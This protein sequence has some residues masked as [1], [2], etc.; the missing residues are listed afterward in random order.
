[1]AQP[2]IHTSFAAGELTPALFARVDLDKYHVG[3]ALLKNFFVDYRGGA[4]T[5]MGTEFIAAAGS[6]NQPRLIPFQFSTVATY[7][8]E[9][10]TNLS[11][12]Y[13]NIYSNG[14]PIL[15][16]PTLVS[17]YAEANLPLLKYAQSADTMTLTHPDYPVYLIKRLAANNFTIS[18]MVIGPTTNS[19]GAITLFPATGGVG[20]LSGY[21]VTAV[22]PAGTEESVPSPIKYLLTDH[23]DPAH[24]VGMKWIAPTGTPPSM[25]KIYKWGP[26]SPNGTPTTVMPTAFGYIGSAFTTQFCDNGITPDFTRQPPQFSDPISPGQITGITITNPGGAYPND[27]PP[28]VTISDGSLAHAVIDWNAGVGGVVID[29]YAHG[30]LVNPT[31]SFSGGS[32]GSGAAASV[33][34]LT[35]LIGTYPSCCSFFQQRLCLGSSLN[36]PNQIWMSQTGSVYNFDASTPTQPSDSITISLAS[37]QVNQ[38]KSMVPMPT[39]LI[40]FTSG[41]AWLLSGGGQ[42]LGVTPTNVTAQPQA[43]SGANDMPP[44]VVNNDVLYVQSRGSTV[45][46]LIYNFY[47]NSYFGQDR[48]ALAN[49]LFFGFQLKEWCFAEEP[50]RTIWAIRDDGVALCLTYVPEQEVYA[51]SHH[52]TQGDFISCCSVVEGQ[53]DAVY[54]IVRR[55]INGAVVNQ[56]E[57]LH[58]RNFYGNAEFPFCLDAGLSLPQTYPNAMI[59]FSAATGNVTIT[60]S[61]S[62]FAPGNVGSVLR[63]LRGGKANITGYI[64]GTQITATVVPDGLG[65]NHFPHVPF[66]NGT[67]APIPANYW[68]IGVPTTTIAGLEYLAGEEVYALADGQVVGPLTVPSSSGGF[69]MEALENYSPSVVAQINANFYNTAPTY[70]MA[71]A[72]NQVVGTAFDFISRNLM[73]IALILTPMASPPDSNKYGWTNAT[74]FTLW[75]GTSPYANGSEIDGTTALSPYIGAKNIDTGDVTYFN[76]YDASKTVPLGVGNLTFSVSSFGSGYTHATVTFSGGGATILAGVAAIYNGTIAGIIITVPDHGLVSAPTVNISGDGSGASYTATFRAG[77]D[78]TWRRVGRDYAL[79]GGNNPVMIN[80]RNHDAFVHSQSC[81][82]YQYRFA[83]NYA[84]VISPYISFNGNN[85]TDSSS[86]RV[87]GLDNVWC[88]CSIMEFSP[89]LQ[90]TTISIVLIPVAITTDE[91]MADQKLPYAIYTVNNAHPLYEDFYRTC[92]GTDGNFYYFAMFFQ[93]ASGM[94]FQLVQF[95]P[96]AFASFGSVVGGTFNDVTPAAWGAGGPTAD[97]VGYFHT[98]PGVHPSAFALLSMFRL[99][100]SNQGVGLVKF[101]KEYKNSTNYNDTSFGCANIQF[102][103]TPT[104]DY[105]S[106]FVTGYMTAAWI[107]TNVAASAAYAVLNYREL[108]LYLDQTDFVYSADYTKRWLYFDCYPVIGGVVQT[109]GGTHIVMVQYQFAYGSAPTVLQVIP[110]DGWDTQYS[111]YGTAIGNTNVV[112]STLWQDVASTAYMGYLTLMRDN[113]IYDAVQ[114]AFYWSGQVDNNNDTA[115]NNLFQ[116]NSVFTPRAALNKPTNTSA[117]AAVTPPFLKL[118]FGSAVTLP[119]PASYVTVGLPYCCRLQTLYLDTGEPTIQ[120]KRK[121]LPALT[122]RVDQCAPMFVGPTFDNLTEYKSPSSAYN[123]TPPFSLVTGDLFTNIPWDWNTYGQVCVQQCNPQPCTVLGL[124]PQVVQG[125]TG[126]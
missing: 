23:S 110:E 38:I 81:E 78:G 67:P 40:L 42:N 84:Q 111:A 74:G 2:T 55:F 118:S 19:P 95:V 125:D 121:L 29:Y 25:Y 109:A 108:D 92:F 64:S 73:Y 69:V 100:A 75:D 117:L 58:S 53:E 124:I 8:L 31:V 82:F 90:A 72:D 10:G 103:V 120:G 99:P 70:P 107:T 122:A 33:V 101:L 51:W 3:A 35:P 18:A 9:F 41:G 83:D 32:P 79:T 71:F 114:N 60:A 76:T 50:F 52:E 119:F 13:I 15:G 93:G 11:G 5:R 43:S 113:G 87:F 59:T 21:L 49:H 36:D 4:S 106:A 85:P 96:P 48:S 102:G 116:L 86:V 47:V 22:N 91:V 63:G 77:S 26:L 105:H 80:P 12:N 98:S 104:A 66:T 34:G 16:T 14:A 37:R 68:F 54:F 65:K 62:V 44:I 24:P 94:E 123:Y 57:R 46:D 126:R 61:A 112:A 97:G 115:S 45:R 56:I 88:Y 27:T 17:P 1:M 7:V 30:N 89:T 6:V 28:T 20:T 39:G